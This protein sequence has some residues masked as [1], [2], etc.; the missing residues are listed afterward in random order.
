MISPHSFHRLVQEGM[1][2]VDQVI[3]TCLSTDA[4]LVRQGTEFMIAAGQERIRPVVTLLAAGALGYDG[5]QQY[6]LAAA[7]ELIQGSLDLHNQVNDPDSVG[8]DLGNA[9]EILLGDLLY[10]GAFKL[11]VGLEDMPVMRVLSDATNVIAEAEVRQRELGASLA[12][13]SPE[14]V[15]LVRGRVAQLFAA[16]TR[17]VG[18]LAGATPVVTDA[19]AA[20]GLHVGTAYQL[21][22]ESADRGQAGQPA[23]ALAREEAVRASAALAPLEDTPSKAALRDYAQ[24]VG[25]GGAE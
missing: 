18:L 17:C 3:R 6:R 20:Y 25:E 4:V 7:V 12:Y 24:L 5:E 10:T 13:A 14:Y 22:Q 11:I 19:L 2:Q 1:A 9:A 23:Q 21:W 8:G 15:A 16:A